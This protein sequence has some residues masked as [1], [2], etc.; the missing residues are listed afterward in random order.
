MY[1]V[2][3]GNALLFTSC[4]AFLSFLVYTTIDSENMALCK[5]ILLLTSFSSLALGQATNYKA[6]AEASLDALQTFYNTSSGLWNTCG[7]WNGANCMTAVND[8][9]TV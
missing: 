4:F 2:L 8:H 7:W 3:S 1:R 6:N 9:T 5:G